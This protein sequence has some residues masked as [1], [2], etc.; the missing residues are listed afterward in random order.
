MIWKQKECVSWLAEWHFCKKYSG[1]CSW[2]YQ[3]AA[4]RKFISELVR[5]WHRVNPKPSS[6][7]PRPMRSFDTNHRALDTLVV[8][9]QWSPS[10]SA[11]TWYPLLN[12]TFKKQKKFL[13]LRSIEKCRTCIVRWRQ[14]GWTEENC[15]SMLMSSSTILL[16]PDLTTMSVSE[17][18]H[19]SYPHDLHTV[20]SE[21]SLVQAEALNPRPTPTFLWRDAGS[22]LIFTS[23]KYPF[24]AYRALC[25]AHTHTKV[26]V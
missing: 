3:K 11:F 18:Q 23:V 4:C 13:K 6:R 8:S 24:R 16:H 9:I 26:I 12:F 14:Q 5:K 7:A 19:H 10:F 25:C 2:F 1:V 15:A 22:N 21:T 17:S 20:K